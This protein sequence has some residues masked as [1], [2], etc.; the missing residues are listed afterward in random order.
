MEMKA[1]LLILAAAVGVILNYSGIGFAQKAT[2]P[3]ASPE[4][5]KQKEEKKGETEPAAPQETRKGKEATEEKNPDKQREKAYQES[6]NARIKKLERT[7]GEK[8]KSW[9]I[10]NR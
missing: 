3:A 9:Q 4:E 5:M 6:R 2:P 10:L 8:V 1:R 7:R